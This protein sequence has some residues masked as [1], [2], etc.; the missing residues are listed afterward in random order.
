ME[1]LG[2]LE[3]ILAMVMLVVATIM[4]IKMGLKYPENQKILNILLG[5]VIWDLSSVYL[6]FI[7]AFW[8]GLSG[9]IIDGTQLSIQIT[10]LINPICAGIW[11]YV[12]TEW[13]YKERRTLILIIWAVIGCLI[14][15]TSIVRLVWG[16]P[17]S[18][19]LVL[20]VPL[21]IHL[22]LV[23]LLV[24]AITIPLLT[25]EFVK[26]EEP[27]IVLRG[28]LLLI[29]F[30]MYFIGVVLGGVIDYGYLDLIFQID[31]I[32]STFLFYCGWYLPE[33]IKNFF[34]K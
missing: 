21:W 23:L 12:F 20:G 9:I 5:I 19:M 28:K 7:F 3:G 18:D 15:Y 1:L 2:F 10:G 16:I 4:A 13:K 30:F 14:E 22:M 32:I 8:L 24:Y 33:N 6:G 17:I 11:L 27:E 31:A 29:A 25:R 26:S 34:L